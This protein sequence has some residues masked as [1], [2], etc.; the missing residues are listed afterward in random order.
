MKSRK[1]NVTIVLKIQSL[2]KHKYGFANIHPFEYIKDHIDLEKA[3]AT[4][5]RMFVSYP[6]GTDIFKAPGSG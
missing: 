2:P 1:K 6:L 4:A 5:E 3:D